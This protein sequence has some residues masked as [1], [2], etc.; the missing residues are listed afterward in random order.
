MRRPLHATEGGTARLVA[1]YGAGAAGFTVG[2]QD[3]KRRQANRIARADSAWTW[4]VVALFLAVVVF[5]IRTLATGTSRVMPE[6][7]AVVIDQ[8][9]PRYLNESFRESTVASLEAFGLPVELFEGEDVDVSLYRSLA[10]RQPGVILIRSHS[11]ILVLEGEEEQRVTAL[12]TNEPYRET[13][14]VAEQLNDRLLVVRPFQ[15]DAVLTFGVSPAFVSRSMQGNLPGSI[16][17]IA[18]CSCLGR[19][20]LADAFIARGASVVVS[21]D[22]SVTLDH[23]DEA[24]ALLVEKLFREGTT[25]ENAV[26]AAMVKYGRDPD[27]GALMTYFPVAAGRY[28]AA[29]LLGQSRR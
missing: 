20:D 10:G 26:I 7:R 25:L 29:Q 4:A 3:R 8:L 14:H 17:I 16:V 28:T 2:Q 5:G 27:F 21:W 12:F 18:G 1:Y 23:V 6:L 24:T 9:S 11:G 13:A 15:D 22:G 19:R